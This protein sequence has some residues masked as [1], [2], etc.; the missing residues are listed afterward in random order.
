MSSC[1]N[2]AYSKPSPRPGGRGLGLSDSKSGHSECLIGRFHEASNVSKIDSLTPTIPRKP[3]RTVGRLCHTRQAAPL[4]RGRGDG[5]LRR[6]SRQVVGK[7][8]TVRAA[9]IR[10]D[11]SASGSMTDTPGCLQRAS[12]ALSSAPQ[13]PKCEVLQVLHPPPTQG[14]KPDRA[15]LQSPWRSLLRIYRLVFAVF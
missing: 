13:A 10:R 1:H 8:S 9:S 6:C 7:G 15:H 11:T 14:P 3:R 12:L 5:P 2:D 4:G